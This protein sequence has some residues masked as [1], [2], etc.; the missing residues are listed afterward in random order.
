[1]SL[2]FDQI[3]YGVCVPALVFFAIFHR[4]SV[5]LLPPVL[6]GMKKKCAYRLT[7]FFSQTIFKMFALLVLP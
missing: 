7:V 3:K 1:V 4:S 5:V 6:G 2:S